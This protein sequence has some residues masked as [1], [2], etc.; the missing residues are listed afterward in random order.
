MNRRTS[1][2]IILKIGRVKL[3]LSSGLL[4]LASALWLLLSPLGFAEGQQTDYERLQRLSSPYDDLYKKYAKRY[5]RGVDWRALQRQGFLES[6]FRDSAVSSVGAQGIAQFLPETWQE[7]QRWEPSLARHT[8]FE[9]AA[10]IYAQAVYMR[11]MWD[12]W[13]EDRSQQDRLALSAASYNAGLGNLIEAQ[14]HCR[15]E[16]GGP[17]RDFNEIAQFLR[18]ITGSHNS[19]ETITYASRIALLPSSKE[20]QAHT[21]KPERFDFLW[22][23]TGGLLSASP[24]RSLCCRWCSCPTLLLRGRP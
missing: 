18:D 16:T 15:R 10:A 9:A 1:D 19:Q 22:T 21:P 3:V 8:P 12:E 4:S 20:D 6:S 5:L 7:V 2:L 17:C 13:T 11:R 23:L 24:D 14:R